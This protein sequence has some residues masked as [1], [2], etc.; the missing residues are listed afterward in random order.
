MKKTICKRTKSFEGVN[1]KTNRS[2]A[3]PKICVALRCV[4][5]FLNLKVINVRTLKMIYR[6]ANCD[7]SSTRRYDLRRHERRKTPCVQNTHDTSSTQSINASE[8][9][10]QNVALEGQ[11]V[12][13]EGQNVALEGQNVALEGQ[14]VALEGQN[15][16]PK[17]CLLYTSPSPRD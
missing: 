2:L 10:G 17:G 15:V 3:R 13:L 1:D 4:I 9:R 8:K 12:A 14:N 16:A 6:C 7:Y 5:A 11:N